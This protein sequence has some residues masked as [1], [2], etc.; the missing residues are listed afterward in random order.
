MTA[1]ADHGKASSSKR[2]SGQKPK[3]SERDPCVLKRTVCKNQRTSV[4]KV[5]GELSIQLQ[6]PVSTQQSGES[7]TTSMVEL[8]LLNH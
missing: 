8:Q 6:D 5:T 7:F 1:Y 4:A 3:L 2:K